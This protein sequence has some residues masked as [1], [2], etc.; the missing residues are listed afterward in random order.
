MENVG[1]GHVIE[2]FECCVLSA[3]YSAAIREFLS[4]KFSNEALE[5]FS[6]L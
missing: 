6:F 5:M 2:D 4:S 3:F 1:L